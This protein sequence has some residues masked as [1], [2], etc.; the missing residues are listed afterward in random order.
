MSKIYIKNMVAKYYFQQRSMQVTGQE[1]INLE[2][3]ENLDGL[4]TH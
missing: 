3:K 2:E 4:G 1:D